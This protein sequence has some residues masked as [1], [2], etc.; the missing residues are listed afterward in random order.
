MM[1]R[2][3]TFTL[4]FG[5]C[6][7]AEAVVDLTGETKLDATLSAIGQSYRQTNDLEATLQAIGLAGT[8]EDATAY[9]EAT[10]QGQTIGQDGTDEYATPFVQMNNTGGMRVEIYGTDSAAFGRTLDQLGCKFNL[11]VATKN[12]YVES[13]T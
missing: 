13:A 1:I 10:L 3:S 2:L 5:L 4:V 12:L 9:L 11:T 6:S 7:F 8:D